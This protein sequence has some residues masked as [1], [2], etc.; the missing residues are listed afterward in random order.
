MAIKIAARKCEIATQIHLPNTLSFPFCNTARSAPILRMEWHSVEAH[1]V[2][3]QSMKVQFI[4][5][6]DSWIRAGA[7]SA[8]QAKLGQTAVRP[9][10]SLSLPLFLEA[11]HSM[12]T[13]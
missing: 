11:A 2:G 1:F 13:N 5:R 3:I 8:F 6:I 4:R 12:S 10:L 9:S 7:R